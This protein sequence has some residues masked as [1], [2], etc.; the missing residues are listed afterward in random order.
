[1][2][3]TKPD[4]SGTR[5]MRCMFVSYDHQE[6]S[7]VAESGF[8]STGSNGSARHACN[9]RRSFNTVAPTVNIETRTA[10]GRKKGAG[11][12]DVSIG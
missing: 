5:Q 3:D 4:I 7:L 2:H 1:M 9:D 8:R 11:Q 10:N 12:G 6:E